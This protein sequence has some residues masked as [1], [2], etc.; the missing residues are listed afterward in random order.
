MYCAPTEQ[1]VTVDGIVERKSV[2]QRRSI[3]P[4]TMIARIDA[5]TASARNILS[6]FAEFWKPRKQQWSSKEATN[7]VYR[8]VKELKAK[9]ETI[10]HPH[11]QV[12]VFAS[13]K[14]RI[15]S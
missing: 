14:T 2:D 1:Y 5:R 4:R 10:R 13:P 12:S 15:L 11:C 3:R 9:H 6:S 7:T 8:P